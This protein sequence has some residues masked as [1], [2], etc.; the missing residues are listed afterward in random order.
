VQQ[1]S[2]SDSILGERT[3]LR[4]EA[5]SD[6]PKGPFVKADRTTNGSAMKVVAM[7]PL[8]AIPYFLV[9]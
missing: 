5:R 1:I 8:V 4:L 3:R 2:S 9:F 7:V 6:R